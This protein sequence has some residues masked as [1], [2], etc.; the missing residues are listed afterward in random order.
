MKKSTY[1]F[2]LLLMSMFTSCGIYSFTGASIPPGAKTVTVKYFQNNA[3]IVQPTLAQ[4]LT[5]KL[6]NRL[7]SQT[8][9][10]LVDKNG[11]LF[12]VGTITDYSVTPIAMQANETAA[13]NRLTV[14]V[15]VKFTNKIDP[16]LD[17]ETSFSEFAD[18]NRT[19]SVSQ[20]EEEQIVEALVDKI[21]NKAVV[22]W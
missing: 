15:S 9:L 17:Y 7:S 22:N 12:F 3:L 2:L 19:S 16:K 1:I 11:D 4:T 13:K 14:T 18:F 6:Q 21:F 10:S 20:T 5:E 8:S